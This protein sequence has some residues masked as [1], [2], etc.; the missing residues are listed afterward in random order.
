VQL[1]ILNGVCGLPSVVILF[2]VIWVFTRGQEKVP[3]TRLISQPDQTRKLTIAARTGVPSSVPPHGRH[4]P[5]RGVRARYG[6]GRVTIVDH[7]QAH[8]LR[9]AGIL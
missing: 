1:R 5:L 4:P 6:H 9:S 7:L 3:F 2:S 8:R